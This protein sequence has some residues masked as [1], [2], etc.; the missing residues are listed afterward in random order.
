MT[1][2]IICPNCGSEIPVS[3]TLTVQIRQ[4]LRRE[5]DQEQKQKEAN[6]AERLEGI[7][8][9]ELQLETSRLALE[10]EVST[11]VAKEQ[12]HLAEEARTKAMESV[13]LEVADLEAQLSEAQDKLIEAFQLDRY[14]PAV[15]S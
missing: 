4:H 1:D 2:T 5:L 14:A 6:L 3:E 9:K 7:R 12:T 11:R 13:A 10:Q 15:R 8:Q